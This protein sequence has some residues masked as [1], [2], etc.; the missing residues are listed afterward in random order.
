MKDEIEFLQKKSILA[1]D[2]FK[3]ADTIATNLEVITRDKYNK[4]VSVKE[5]YDKR[6]VE[7]INVGNGQGD[8]QGGLVAQN[9]AT[10][11]A[12]IDS[13]KDGDMWGSR[14]GLLF[15]LRQGLIEGLIKGHEEGYVHGLNAP[16]NYEKGFELGVEQGV[17]DARI[18]A[19]NNS[20]P[21]GRK[22]QKEKL[23]IYHS[24]QP[25]DIG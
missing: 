15:G 25:S 16:E 20:Y 19:V 24:H 12:K 4:Y 3:E 6:L 2:N 8:H 10:K 18:Y 1:F 14:K 23:L 22:F 21:Q 7:S 11:I 13:G 9:Y 17:I 5:L